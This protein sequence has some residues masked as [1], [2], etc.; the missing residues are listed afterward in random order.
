M[1][2][3]N[4][5][6]GAGGVRGYG[7]V[8]GIEELRAQINRVAKVPKRVISKAAREG[9]R[10]PL[11]DARRGAPRRTGTLKKGIRSVME[12]ATKRKKYKTVYQIVFDRKYTEIFKG[13]KIIR[14]GLY[15]ANPPRE[16]GYYPISQEYGFKASYGF[17]EGV[18]FLEDAIKNN[19]DDSLKKIV[20]VLTD[21]I[22]KLTR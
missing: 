2:N 5:V 16:Y 7:Y 19:V 1:A 17:H 13:K 9:V 15:G 12:A 10:K 18:H 8:E 3:N 14:P 22:D 6:T 11:A 4:R 20:R 21:E